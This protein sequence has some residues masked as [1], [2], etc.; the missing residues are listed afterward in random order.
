MASISPL[1][2][3]P[4]RVPGQL[5]DEEIERRVNERTMEYFLAAACFFALAGMEWIG[6]QSA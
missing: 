5:L 3:R 2:D 1:T 6:K 4:L